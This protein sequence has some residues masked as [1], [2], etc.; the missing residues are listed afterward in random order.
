MGNKS[1]IY[2][3]AAESTA[4]ILAVNLCYIMATIFDDAELELQPLRRMR[5][6]ISRVD[7]RFKGMIMHM[8]E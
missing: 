6:I 2:L 7:I 5:F 4:A 1:S 8:A 3:S